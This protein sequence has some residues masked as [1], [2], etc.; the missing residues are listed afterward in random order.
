M[1]DEATGSRNWADRKDYPDSLSLDDELWSLA[2]RSYL[3]LEERYPRGEPLPVEK[4]ILV[5]VMRRGLLDPDSEDRP[6][7]GSTRAMR[8]AACLSDHLLALVEDERT[9]SEQLLDLFID[10]TE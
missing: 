9:R 3:F 4:H 1:V 10:E 7:H 2:M 6:F 8:Y 5:K